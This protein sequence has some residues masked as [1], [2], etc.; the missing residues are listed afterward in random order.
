MFFNF[1]NLR[2]ARGG[3]FFL[4]FFFCSCMKAMMFEDVCIEG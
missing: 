4:G 2:T 3:V 1:F